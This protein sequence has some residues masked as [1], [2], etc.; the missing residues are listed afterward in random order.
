MNEMNAINKPDD[1]IM[2]AYEEWKSS[3]SE[4]STGKLPSA[5]D[6]RS[7]RRCIPSLE[8]WKGHLKLRAQTMALKAAGN[9]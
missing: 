2:G 4:E 9:I 8:G 7:G 6:G 1:P 5:L 3:K